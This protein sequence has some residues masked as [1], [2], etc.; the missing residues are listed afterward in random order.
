MRGYFTASGFIFA[1]RKCL[2]YI[3]KR[4]QGT[5]IA[6]VRIEGRP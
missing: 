4:L 1:I 2:C 5:G 6:D 3:T